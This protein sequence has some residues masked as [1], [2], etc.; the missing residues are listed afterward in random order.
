MGLPTTERAVK[1]A[2]DKLGR[3]LPLEL[4]ARLLR[5]NGGE[6]LVQWEDGEDGEWQLHPVWDDSDRQTMRRSSNHLV[7]EQESAKGW[8]GFPAD[9][10]SIA[11]R[12]GDQLILFPDRDD[13]KLWLHETGDVESVKVVW[14]P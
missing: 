12:D 9:A 13:P 14:D 4:R 1:A 3:S 11:T 8:P 10:I 2:E 7:R 6:I 5:N